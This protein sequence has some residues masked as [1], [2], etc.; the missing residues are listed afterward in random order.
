MN[1]EILYSY[2]DASNYK[3]H[4][5]EILEG[6]INNEQIYAIISCLE[7]GE[8]F[9]PS[10]VG[11]DDLQ[12]E[13]QA[14]D[15]KDWDDDHCW[16]EINSE[17]FSPTDKEPTCSLT[18]K[19]LVKNFKKARHEGWHLFEVGHKLTNNFAGKTPTHQ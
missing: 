4:R 5:Y 9:I 17:S 6:K 10:Q 11:L 14:H 2:R 19:Q 8:L 12:G 16:H 7:D 1:T 3:T 15:T 18:I 13:L